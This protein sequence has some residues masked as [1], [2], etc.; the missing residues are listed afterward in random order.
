[1]ASGI[2]VD[3]EWRHWQVK[4]VEEACRSDRLSLSRAVVGLVSWCLLMQS[5]YDVGSTKSRRL[6]AL[7]E[8]MK[9]SYSHVWD[10]FDPTTANRAR[11]EFLRHCKSSAVSI[12]VLV[13]VL[14]ATFDP[15]TVVLGN[16]STEVFIAYTISSEPEAIRSLSLDEHQR[17]VLAAIA[18]ARTVFERQTNVWELWGL[19]DSANGI[20]ELL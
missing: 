10:L 18:E 11:L 15:F 7:T 6:W 17:Q 3:D 8:G 14:I 12:D 4:L 19:P 13:H 2:H 5:G 9:I 16:T 20:R 1:V